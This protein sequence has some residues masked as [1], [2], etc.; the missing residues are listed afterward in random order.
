[1][2]L[3]KFI[4][5]TKGRMT[6]VFDDSGAITPVTAVTAGPIVITAVKTVES[7]GYQAVQTGFGT[8]RE[9][10]AT[11]AERGHFKEIPF[12]QVVRE[13][14]GEVAQQRGDTVDVSIFAP[15]DIIEVSA[16]SKGKGFQGGVKRHGFAGSPGSHG[17]K[18]YERSPGS[19]GMR[20]PQR[21]LKGKRMAGRMGSDRVTVKNLRVVQVHPETN[22]MLI[23][24]AIPGKPGTI[25]E[26][27]SI[28]Q[29]NK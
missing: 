26:I 22:T 13:F 16:I 21:V 20:W 2:A 17:H 6:Q 8:R 12:P 1:M 5:G 9:S 27:R 29:K 19:I 4:L 7:D 10:L 14:R 24:G 11:K 3:E 23:S 18:R 15:G 25:V 28:E